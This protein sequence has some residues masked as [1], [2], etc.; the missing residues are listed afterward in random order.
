MICR[1]P[2]EGLAGILATPIGVMQQR[3]R[4]VASAN[5]HE[6]SIN[7][8]LARHSRT[9][10]PTH[11]AP[12]EQIDDRRYVKPSFRRPDVGEVSNP[13]AVGSDGLEVAIQRI[14]SDPT[15]QA[16]HLDQVAAGAVWGAL[17]TLVCASAVRS[18]AAHRPHRLRADHATHAGP[19]KCGH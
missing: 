9:H 15:W 8:E 12:G 10:R 2:L 3:A 7:R 13:F 5:C 1:E 17:L 4:I 11:N 19:R 18:G 6:Q 16:C 14:G